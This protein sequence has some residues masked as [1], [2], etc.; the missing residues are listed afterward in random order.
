MLNFPGC[1]FYERLLLM[2]YLKESLTFE[3]QAELLIKRGLI[4]D[5]K[6]FLIDRLSS[7][8]YYRLSAYLFPFRIE[9]SDNFKQGTKFSDI[10]HRYT[11][12]RRFRCLIFDAVER[13]ETALKTKL[14]NKFTLKY[15][16]FGYLDI[17]NFHQFQQSD[18]DKMQKI[19]KE[20]VKH[21]EKNEIF[22]KHF[23][24]KYEDKHLPLWMVSEVI[25]YGTMLIM[26]KH[27]QYHFKQEIAREFNTQ[28]QVFESWVLCLS[29]IRNICAHHARLWNRRLGIKPRIP[30]PRK[31]PDWHGASNEKP[32]VILLIL[33]HLLHR[34]AP[35]SHWKE[36]I[37]NLM[38]EYKDLPLQNMGFPKDWQS[39]PLWRN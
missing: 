37:E 22:V 31:H 8:N 29:V 25:S 39:H 5:D 9:G 28:L 3:Q 6:S 26:F 35:K 17:K 4:V 34:C 18:F 11:F 13:F 30:N 12:D 23:K 15:G 24:A 32:F 27:L 36:R 33:N 10:Y 21:A 20:D 7:I 1:F 2:K 38:N 19:I 14:V 16:P